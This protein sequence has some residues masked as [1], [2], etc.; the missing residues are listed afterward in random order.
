MV[1]GY[2]VKEREV[3]IVLRAHDLAEEM[4]DMIVMDLLDVVRSQ[5]DRIEDA[6]AYGEDEEERME[7]A[8]CEIEV[9]LMESGHLR[10][11]KHFEMLEG[12]GA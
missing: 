3:F 9:V 10:G 2:L 7:F 8:L 5:G 11:D 12:V 4:D 6:A 1:D